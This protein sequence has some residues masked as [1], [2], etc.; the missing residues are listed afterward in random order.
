MSTLETGNE[1]V[2]CSGVQCE[3]HEPADV[4]LVLARR[5]LIADTS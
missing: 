5:P 2:T 4:V 1:S 3:E